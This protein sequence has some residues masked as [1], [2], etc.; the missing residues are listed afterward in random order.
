MRS[1]GRSGFR[2]Q[3]AAISKLLDMPAERPIP[4]FGVI[5]PRADPR[6]NRHREGGEGSS[7]QISVAGSPSPEPSRLTA[8]TCDFIQ[9]AA[10]FT[11]AAPFFFMN[12][13]FSKSELF[14]LALILDR[15]QS[16]RFFATQ[17]LLPISDCELRIT[18]LEE[19]VLLTNSLGQDAA[20]PDCPDNLS[21]FSKLRRWTSSPCQS[22]S[23]PSSTS[24]AKSSTRTRSR[25]TAIH[26]LAAVNLVHFNYAS[27]KGGEPVDRLD[28]LFP[29][30]EVSLALRA[31][32]SQT[33]VKF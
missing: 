18:M 21:L 2:Q 26:S 19:S 10:H 4:L 5:R 13:I 27:E 3:I 30:G 20:D 33:D 14:I 6:P 11:W 24:V 16:R 7:P 32:L 22:L 1:H 15:K 23:L 17:D 25:R 12:P 31:M 29:R 28:V 9:R 8:L